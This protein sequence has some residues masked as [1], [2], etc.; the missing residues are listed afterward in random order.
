MERRLFEEYLDAQERFPR[1]GW[2][3]ARRSF[4]FGGVKETG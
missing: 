3:K 1:S 2:H 4:F